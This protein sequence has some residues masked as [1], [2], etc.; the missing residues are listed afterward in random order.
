MITIELGLYIFT[1]IV[2]TYIAIICLLIGKTWGGGGKFWYLISMGFTIFAVT[3]IL[4]LI[5]NLTSTISSLLTLILVAIGF[6]LI[7]LGKTSLYKTMRGIIPH[8]SKEG[9]Q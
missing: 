5:Y 4:L 6:T 9:M 3:R 7:A 8:K 1:A 2:A